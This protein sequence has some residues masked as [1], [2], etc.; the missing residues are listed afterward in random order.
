MPPPPPSLSTE[1]ENTLFFGD[2]FVRLFGLVHE[3]RQRGLQ[4]RHV[5]AFKG[6]TAKGLT[7][8]GHENRERI[9]TALRRQPHVR[10]AVFVF[11][12]V[13]V[14]HSYYFCKYR[15]KAPMDFEALA[16][17]Y[18][19]FVASVEPSR[20][21]L[22]KIVIGVY[23]SPLEDQFVGL[24]L[25][26]YGVLEEEH[27]RELE[28]QQDDHTLGQR[29]AR[30]QEFNALLRR[31]CL[32][33]GVQYADAFDEMTDAQTKAVRAEFRDVSDHNIHVTW[34]TTLEIW[35]Q[36]LPWLAAFAPPHFREQL[37]QGLE[38]YLKTKPWATREHV[39][40]SSNADTT[41]LPPTEVRAAPQY[42]R[43]Q[44]Q[45]DPLP[46][47][48]KKLP[49]DGWGKYVRKTKPP[50]QA[51]TR[52]NPPREHV[53]VSSSAGTTTPPLPTEVRAVPVPQHLRQPK[54]K[55]E[56][57]L[58]SER[59][60]L[61]PA[62]Y[63]WGKYRHRKAKPPPLAELAEARPGPPQRQQQEIGDPFPPVKD[64]APTCITAEIFEQIWRM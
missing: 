29:Q 49:P 36:K 27:R 19:D 62:P 54:Q 6:A 40:V 52:P 23:P 35:L 37:R 4:R 9:G 31:F 46:S 5:H 1:A 38:G 16:R 41:P 18:V 45:E 50:P 63:G 51:E 64:C 56:D 26:H 24:S 28:A 60:K 14:Q 34:E 21:D 44:K 57:P 20:P 25:V 47:E 11:G 22:H 55:K 10:T 61:P 43:Q 30:V 59:K 33:R 58:L 13:D 15:K 7:K 53:C 32:E 3:A 2:S 12:N 48:R 8:A 17:G 42:L 39:C